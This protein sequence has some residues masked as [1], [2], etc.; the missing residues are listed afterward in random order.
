[1]TTNTE[2]RDEHYSEHELTMRAIDRLGESLSELKK[3]L[4]DQAVTFC[5]HP[6]LT[7]RVLPGDVFVI[8][9]KNVISSHEAQL[10]KDKAQSILPEGVRVMVIDQEVDISTVRSSR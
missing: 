10:L 7:L 9:A 5:G 6:T 4:H 2:L 3:T 8:K 1:M